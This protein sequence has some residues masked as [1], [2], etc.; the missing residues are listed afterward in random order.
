MTMTSL[1]HNGDTRAEK[2]SGSSLWPLGL[3]GAIFVMAVGLLLEIWGRKSGAAL[4]VLGGLAVVVCLM[5]WANNLIH[6]AAAQPAND[7]MTD[8]RWM[9]NGVKLFLA[10]E[11]A[12]FGAFFAHHFY[13][14]WHAS[15]WPPPG[16]PTLSTHLPAI[17]TLIL[18]SSSATMQWAHSYL[19]RG[20]RTQ[21]TAFTLVTILLGV[22]FLGFQ[23]HEWGFLKAYD[24]F[25]QSTGAFGTSF[26]TMTGFHGLHVTVGIVML[27]IV[28]F[29]L[30]LGHFDQQKHF[31]FIA[32]TW[33]WH[34]VDFIWILLFFTMYL[35]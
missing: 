11:T 17:A 26:Y 30:R 13:A 5:G 32:A 8:D 23:G 10:S 24:N 19:L 35:L 6:E 3:A 31:A 28:W 20:K 34:F 29:R 2:E 21:A 16:A 18:M 33:Y 27:A 1:R 15:T 7:R 9:R 22:I 4:L 25:T 12:I 14:E